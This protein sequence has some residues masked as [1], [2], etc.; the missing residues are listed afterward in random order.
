[1]S[2]WTPDGEHEVSNKPNQAKPA[3]NAGAVAGDP[4]DFDLE[5]L[6]PEE[7]AQAEAMAQELQEARERLSQTPASLVI[8][9]HVMGLYELAAIHLSDT[10][11]RL[12]EAK[13]AVDAMGALLDA[14]EGQL[15]EHEE[16]LR[17]ARSQIQLA[18]VQV[19][20]AVKGECAC[21]NADCKK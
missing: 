19:S 9:N 18:Y 6:S 3:Q 14:L 10:T 2:L 17:G 15:G 16:T 13:L 5:N 8:S 20:S 12:S 11:P 4:G 7:R 1:M 21:G